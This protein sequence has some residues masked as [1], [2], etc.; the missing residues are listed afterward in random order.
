MR[1]FRPIWA[2]INCDNLIYNFGL[3]RETVG[4]EVRVMAVVKA[5]A[6]GHGAVAVAR[7]LSTAGVDAFG[8]A[9]L[10]EAIELREAGIAGNILV[11]GYTQPTWASEV[12]EYD[13]QQTLYHQNLALALS[14]E[15][16]ARNRIVKIHVKIDTGMGRIG[17]SPENALPFIENLFKLPGIKVEGIFTHLSCVDILDEEYTASQLT[18]FSHLISELDSAGLKI[19]TRHAAN[20]A[21]TLHYPLSHLDMVRTGIMIYGLFPS[22]Q[23]KTI[24]TGLRPAMS[25]KSMVVELKTVSAGTRISYSGTF[26]T[27]KT[28]RIATLPVGYADGFSRRLSNTGSVLIAGRRAPIVGNVCMDFLMVDVSNVPEVKVN[29]EAA[30]VGRQGG[31]EISVDEIAAQLG[32]INYEVITLIGKRVHRVYT[33]YSSGNPLNI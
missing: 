14:R 27:T 17:I 31:E 19:P 18:R 22:E 16:T 11:L 26:K 23:F 20:S 12:V 2:E 21:G 29:D 13:V 15:A 3:A 6:Y 7:V 4:S 33:H 10:E 9:S 28:T 1:I 24:K 25:I 8:V 30:L 32:T 5:D